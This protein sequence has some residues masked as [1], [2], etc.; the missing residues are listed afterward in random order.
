M[1]VS[2]NFDWLIRFLLSKQRICKTCRIFENRLCGDVQEGWIW[3]MSTSPLTCEPNAYLLWS[4]FEHL[5]CL[6]PCSLVTYTT[7]EKIMYGNQHTI[8][9]LFLHYIHQFT[10]QPIGYRN[11]SLAFPGLDTPPTSL[12]LHQDS[13][14]KWTWIHWYL[15]YALWSSIV[16]LA[17]CWLP[18]DMFVNSCLAIWTPVKP[19]SWIFVQRANQEH[20]YPHIWKAVQRLRLNGDWRVC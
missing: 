17:T 1:L 12:L 6:V 2:H 20:P 18:T 9:P 3:E 4:A 10:Q 16:L 5:M 13:H 7:D 14:L 15:P 19:S 8:Y 11:H